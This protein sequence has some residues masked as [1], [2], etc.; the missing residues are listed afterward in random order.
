RENIDEGKEAAESR[1]TAPRE[2][3]WKDSSLES[4]AAVQFFEDLA[5]SREL[6]EIM[7]MEAE[8]HSIPA[9][10]LFA[11][12]RAESS[13]NPWAINK[14]AGS[15]DRGLF[16]LN[17]R[18]FPALAESDFFDPRVNA[19][20]GAA[21]LRACLDAGENE[22]VALAMYNAGKRRVDTHG[23]PK[24]T[25]NYIAKVLDYRDK[26]EESLKKRFNYREE[27]HVRVNTRNTPADGVDSAGRNK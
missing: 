13:F 9:P 17:S 4:E 11:L 25:L 20:Y 14:N 26:I 6:A 24:M 10:L 5:G 15:V 21:Y 2:E 19:E 7:L 27:R 22:V 1:K 12:V 18:S 16:Q 3:A 8:K 23:T